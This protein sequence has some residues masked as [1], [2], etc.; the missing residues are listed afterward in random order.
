MRKFLSA[1]LVCVCMITSLV[2]C[3][4]NQPRGK[5]DFSSVLANEQTVESSTKTVNT[6]ESETTT[7]EEETTTERVAEV[8]GSRKNP[9][10]FNTDFTT[11]YVKYSHSGETRGYTIKISEILRG[12]EA[13][14]VAVEANQFNAGKVP[15]G[16]DLILFKVDF[17]LNK[18]TAVE[19]F[20]CSSIYFKYFSSSFGEENTFISIS[21]LEKLHAEL[22]EG[23][24]TS[25]WLYTLVDT[26][27]PAPLVRFDEMVWL[28]LYK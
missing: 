19:S 12:A 27:D 2:G 10:P 11:E 16:K 14:T 17:T 4:D 22:Y 1:L 15:E 26:S 18:L 24:S 9:V 20:L 7:V 8:L 21:G 6:S 5:K 13:E 25:G 3:N 28:A 23:G